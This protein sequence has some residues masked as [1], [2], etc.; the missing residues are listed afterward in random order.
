MVVV[1]FYFV[2]ELK[3]FSKF[4]TVFPGYTIDDPTF[5]FETVVQHRTNVLIN[6]FDFIF[7]SYFVKKIGSVETTLKENNILFN[8]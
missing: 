4:F 5:V 6:A 2:L 3:F 1:T 8:S 7:E